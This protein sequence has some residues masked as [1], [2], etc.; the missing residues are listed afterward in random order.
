MQIN[1]EF[2][3]QADDTLPVGKYFTALNDANYVGPVFGASPV[4]RAGRLIFVPT[5]ESDDIKQIEPYIVGVMGKSIIE[6]GTDVKKSL[7]LKIVG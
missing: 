4:A 5:G 1:S 7:T 3:R 6:L 2:S